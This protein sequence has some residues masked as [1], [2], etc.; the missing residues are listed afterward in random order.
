MPRARKPGHGLGGRPRQK[1]KPGELVTLTL[2]MTAAQRE[3]VTDAAKSSGFSVSGW[4]VEMATR[5]GSGAS[6]VRPA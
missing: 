1:R 2:R 4:V 3:A 5:A 6:E